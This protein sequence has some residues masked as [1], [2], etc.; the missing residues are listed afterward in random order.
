MV[1]ETY[2]KDTRAVRKDIAR[3]LC[4]SN[5][6]LWKNLSEG[7]REAVIDE[8][9]DILSPDRISLASVIEDYWLVRRMI[10]GTV[11]GVLL[12]F[13]G[14]LAAAA[15]AKYL[16]SSIIADLVFIG[17]FIFLL[18]L[19]LHEVAKLN[20]FNLKRDKILERLVEMLRKSKT[21]LP[22]E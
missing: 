13:S 4:K 7:E 12:G 14:A 20:V 3:E 21:D 10:G 8:F 6:E 17:F 2:D 15:V 9:G 22:R 19:T 5:K 11:L 1:M 16:P 18:W